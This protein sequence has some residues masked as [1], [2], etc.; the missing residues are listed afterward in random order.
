MGTV[1]RMAV[2]ALSGAVLGMAVSASPAVAQERG[3]PGTFDY[4]LFSLS[5]S[6]AYC[7]RAGKD[8]AP[9]QCAASDPRGFV[10]HGLWPQYEK[11]GWPE[12]CSFG[13]RVP[14]VIVDA[15]LEVMPTVELIDHEWAKHGTC[16][17][18]TP[19]LYF[20]ETRAAWE[21]V[22]IPPEFFTPDPGLS[23]TAKE[24]E[25]RFIAVNDN[26][27]PDR[28]AVV[29]DRRGVYEVR[30]CMD[31]DLVFRDCGAKVEDRCRAN[32]TMTVR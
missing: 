19:D 17:G 10:V 18:L 4:Y 28:I 30:V 13:R 22:R 5:W 7:A 26:L 9:E 25:E 11:G 23:V 1:R 15:M 31:K 21:R 20:A 3:T 14:R 32:A 27:T 8:A 12:T 2:A 29:C 24:V 6:P 16:S